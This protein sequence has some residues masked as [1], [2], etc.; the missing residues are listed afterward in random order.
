V[1]LGL[2]PL[3]TVLVPGGSLRLHIFE[4]RY[5]ELIGACIEQG[6]PFGVVLDRAGNEVGDDLDPATVGTTAEIR[7]VTHLPEGR[8]FIVTRGIRRFRVVKFL[9]TK[10]FWAAEVSYLDENTGPLETALRLRATALERFRDYLQALL[11]LSGRELEVV[12]LPEDPAASSFL[13]A[14]AMQV[15]VAAKQTLLESPSAAERLVAELKLLDDEIRRLRAARS[16]ESE[17][18]DG[19][20]R[21]NTF[22]VRISL[23]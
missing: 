14:E 13:I 6:M 15:D 19:D 18:G 5:K 12:Q 21:R 9:Q 11:H 4:D 7:E 22:K 3:R 20:E 23:N 10:P 8:L 1:S 17:T 16:D 2:F